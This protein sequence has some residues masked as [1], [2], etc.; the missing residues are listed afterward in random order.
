LGRIAR[1]VYR[2]QRDFD[3]EI[4]VEFSSHFCGLTEMW[5]RGASWDQ[6]RHA[7]MYDEGDVVRALRRTLDLCRQFMRAE[8]VPESLSEACRLV[9][10]L[11]NRDEVREDF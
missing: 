11:I 5:A 7:T 3:I 2:V 10:K 4:P 6:V 1:S 8:G 9:E